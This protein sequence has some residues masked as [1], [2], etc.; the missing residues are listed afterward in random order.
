LPRRCTKAVRPEIGDRILAKEVRSIAAWILIPKLIHDLRADDV[1]GNAERAETLLL[2]LWPGSRPALEEALTAPDRQVRLIAASI[3]R[4]KCAMDASDAL[5]TACIEDLRDDGGQTLWWTLDN[6]QSSVAYLCNFPQ[7]VQ[8]L[9][10]AAMRSDDEQQRFL[11]AAIAGA[12][13]LAPLLDRA[14]PILIPHLRDNQLSGDAMIAVPALYDF[15]PDAIP[16]LE[17]EF[18]SDDAQLR[19]ISRAIAER[20]QH[21]ERT[22]DTVRNRMPHLTDLTNDPLHLALEDGVRNLIFHQ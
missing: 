8:P 19:A 21:P 13:H 20:L 1:R 9:L 7:R 4:E 15:G 10:P 22:I 11:A 14:A 17:A 16:Y 6:A 12:C 5:L 3:L 2:E 18:N